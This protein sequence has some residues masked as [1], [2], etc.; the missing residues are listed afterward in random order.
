M[1][2][3]RRLHGLQQSAHIPPHGQQRLPGGGTQNTGPSGE[4]EGQHGTGGFE[5]YVALEK[6]F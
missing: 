1:G 5:K 2:S 6:T 4:S 3:S